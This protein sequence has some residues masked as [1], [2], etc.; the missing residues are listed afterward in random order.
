MV[1]PTV[2]LTQPGGPF[3]YGEALLTDGRGGYTIA[4]SLRPYF[5]GY[6]IPRQLEQ[7]EALACEHHG[8]D[9]TV[10]GFVVTLTLNLIGVSLNLNKS[11]RR[12]AA[13]Q[14]EVLVGCSGKMRCIAKLDIERGATTFRRD[15]SE[16]IK[17][18]QALGV[19]IRQTKGTKQSVF[20]GGLVGLELEG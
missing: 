18:G 6:A 3:D 16:E 20:T 5:L 9:S 13:Y 17:A 11:I 7:G 8:V 10:A 1:D 12:G 15:L 4:P 14:V 2:E 19:R